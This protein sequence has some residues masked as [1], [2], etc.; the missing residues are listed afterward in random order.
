MRSIGTAIA[1]AL[2][3]TILASSVIDLGGGAEVPSE[4]SF[5]LVFI[6]GGLAALG[7]ALLALA[8][9]SKYVRSPA[10]LGAIEANQSSEKVA[11]ATE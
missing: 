6:V 3:A 2:M 9:P 1:S 7:A 8:I 11:T 4:S 10:S 5:R